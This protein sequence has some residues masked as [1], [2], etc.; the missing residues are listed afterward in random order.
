[1]G[2]GKPNHTVNIVVVLFLISLVGYGGWS[3]LQQ[4]LEGRK[5]AKE[6]LVPGALKMIHQRQA[7]YHEADRDGD[8]KLEYG[9]LQALSVTH[10]G[11]EPID[12]VL[13]G[14]TKNGYLYDVSLSALPDEEAWFATAQPQLPGTTGDAFFAVNHE[15]VIYVS[16]S[17]IPMNTEDCTFPAA[18]LKSGDLQP[19]KR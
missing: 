9:T 10:P 14:G 6:W 13:A 5:A 12:Q 2:E 8:G 15:G 1:M 19:V 16:Q 7:A 4:R 18:R 17:P 3:F 11:Y